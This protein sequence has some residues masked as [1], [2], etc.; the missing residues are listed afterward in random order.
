MHLLLITQHSH[1]I[2]IGYST[3]G[4]SEIFMFSHYFTALTVISVCILSHRVVDWKTGKA[5][6]KHYTCL[7]KTIKQRREKVHM[8]S[9]TSIS[10]SVSAS[11]TFNRKLIVYG[12]LSASLPFRAC[13]DSAKHTL[14]YGCQPYGPVESVTSP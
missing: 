7:N 6:T 8:S 1:D 9:S 2:Q 5:E 12:F 3:S 13:C 4:E 11:P 10:S 14:C